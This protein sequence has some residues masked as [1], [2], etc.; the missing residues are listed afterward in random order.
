MATA[1]AVTVRAVLVVAMAALCAVCAVASEI[2]PPSGWVSEHGRQHPLTGRAFAPGEGRF[3]T[4]EE[5]RAAVRDNPVVLLGE[6][7]DNPDHHALRAVLLDGKRSAV[8]EHLRV[9]QAG[10][11][12]GLEAARVAGHALPSAAALLEQLDWKRSGWPEARLFEPLFQSVLASRMAIVAGDPERGR[13]RTIARGGF[14]ALAEGEAARLGLDRPL[15]VA[16]DAQL[17]DE[18]E[19]SHCGLMPRTAFTNMAL[20]QRYRDAHLAVRLVQA[21]TAHGSAV[22]LTGNGHARKDRGVPW[23]LAGLP[24]G[25]APFVVMLLEVADGRDDAAAYAK[26]GSDGRPTADIVVFTPRAEREDPCEA[27]RRAFGKR[28]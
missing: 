11:L 3:L 6:V 23:Y 2:L 10:V 28:Q 9:D 24:S 13:V 7:H 12:D 27:M 26:P 5:F 21:A 20:A 4:A 19:A 8:F 1:V 14:A 15:G 18:L 17:L 22:L 16:A 25:G